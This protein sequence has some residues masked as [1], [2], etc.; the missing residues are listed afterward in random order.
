MVALTAV[1][2]RDP[3]ILRA[4]VPNQLLATPNLLEEN[5]IM[6]T[7]LLITT[8][9]AAVLTAVCKPSTEKPVGQT[10]ET[11][12]QPQEKTDSSSPDAALQPR[13]Y[14]F[15]QKTEFLM[16]MRAQLSELNAS[17]DG[18]SVKIDKSSEAVQAEAKPKLAVLREKATELNKKLD[19]IGNAT[20]PTWNVMKTET[21]KAFADLK[22]GI[23][24]SNQ[25]ISDKVSP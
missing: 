18:V 3:T 13:D 20:L 9:L 1:P 16:A 19:D 5:Y 17:V 11:T 8:L 21:E 10:T 14:N 25:A 12:A 23:A 24:Q 4:N 15:G 2:S 22:D 7:I 6:K